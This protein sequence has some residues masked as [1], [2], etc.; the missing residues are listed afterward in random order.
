MTGR[1]CTDEGDASGVSRPAAGACAVSGAAEP[2]IL[3]EGLSKRFG[4]REAVRDLSFAVERGGFLA[5]FGPNGAGKT[6]TLRVLAGLASPT[7]GR[8]LVAGMDVREDPLPLRRVVGFISHNPLLYPDLSAYENLRFFA[9]MYGVGVDAGAR[10]ARI[11]E[12]LERVELP[13][14]RNDTVRTFSRGMRQRLAIARAILHAP[15]VLLLDE[16]HAGLDARAVGILD[17]LLAEIRGD[18]TFVMVT[19]SPL[20]GLAM[21]TRALVLD[22]GRVALNEVCDEGGREALAGTVRARLSA[23]VPEVAAVRP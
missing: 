19:H 14:R 20:H 2:E 22:A 18:H 3:V 13:M 21:A 10:D 8:V 16:P 17:G 15:R 9:D 5:V 4:R 23:A 1:G 6:T 7:A 11:A 12:L